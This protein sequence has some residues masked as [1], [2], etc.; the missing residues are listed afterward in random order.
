MRRHNLEHV[1]LA[2]SLLWRNLQG[3]VCAH[4]RVDVGV[5]VGVRRSISLFPLAFPLALS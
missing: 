2:Q 5:G 3:R 1:A 4:T